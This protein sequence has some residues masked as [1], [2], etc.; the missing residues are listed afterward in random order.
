[1]HVVFVSS[2]TKHLLKGKVQT[3]LTASMFSYIFDWFFNTNCGIYTLPVLVQ[4]VVLL[5][6]I[7]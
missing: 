4:E 3:S 1:M 6:K 5:K 2:I 7:I